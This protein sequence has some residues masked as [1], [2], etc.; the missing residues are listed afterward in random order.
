[1]TKKKNILQYTVHF[2]PEEE[3]GGFTVEVPALPGCITY[4]DT[5][6]EAKRYAAEAIKLYLEVLAERGYPAPEDDDV[7][8][9]KGK[10][11]VLLNHQFA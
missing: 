5:L 8:F 9:L 10:V 2:I 6:A 11:Q 4:G 3:T 7:N 1:M